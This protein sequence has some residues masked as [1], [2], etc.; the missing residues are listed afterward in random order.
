M[1][2][3]V[4]RARRAIAIVVMGLAAGSAAAANFRPMLPVI[5]RLLLDDEPG[6]QQRIAAASAT[7]AGN[8]A[9]TALTPFYWEIGDRNSRLAEGRGGNDP[10]A[11]PDADTS[12]A[13]ASA[14]KWVFSTYAVEKRAGQISAA[15]IKLLNFTSGH[16]NFANCPALSSVAGCLEAPGEDGGTNG[17]YVPEHDGKYYYNGGHMQVLADAM[18]LGAMHNAALAAEVRSVLGTDLNLAYFQPQPPGGIYTTP[19]DYARFLRRLLDGSYSHMGP[20]LGSHA[21]CAHP[22]SAECPSAIYSPLNQSQ[23]GPVNDLGDE[24]WHYSLGHW[25][26]DDPQTGDGAFSSAGGFGFYPWIDRSKTY[27]GVLARVDTRTSHTRPAG[28]ESVDCGRLI[29]AA[30]LDGRPR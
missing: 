25:V 8:P 7:A 16:T 9:C 10:A 4:K 19:A 6:L 11:A 13:I 17:D 3:F 26:E 30:W 22:N 18:G 23:P 28:K 20:L 14:S 5:T 2:Q 24:S 29:R 21:A 15:D 1:S 27:Y 12:M